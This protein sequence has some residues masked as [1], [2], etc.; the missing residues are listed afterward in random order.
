MGLF[1]GFLAALAANYRSIGQDD[2]HGYTSRA[3]L[4]EVEKGSFQIGEELISVGVVAHQ[5]EEAVEAYSPL[6][7]LKRR[8]FLVELV[9]PVRDL[10]I[11]LTGTSRP[12]ADVAHS[13]MCDSSGHC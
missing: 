10:A 13:D 7:E 5:L 12:L 4:G 1:Y 11:G 6:R 3:S 2:D 8:L 9:R